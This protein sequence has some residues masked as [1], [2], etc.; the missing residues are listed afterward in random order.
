MDIENLPTPVLLTFGLGFD[1]LAVHA[2]AVLVG[3]DDLEDVLG[4][5][6]QVVDDD[7]ARVRRVHGHLDPVRELG[8]LLAVPEEKRVVIVMVNT[9]QHA[10]SIQDNL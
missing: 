8:V 4:V 3:A 9:Q 7:L 6:H 5:G 1:D 2:V 10:I